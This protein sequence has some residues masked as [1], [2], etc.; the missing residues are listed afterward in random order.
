MAKAFNLTGIDFGSGD[1]QTQLQGLG[2]FTSNYNTLLDKLGTLEG[3]KVTSSGITIGQKIGDNTAVKLGN[4][5]FNLSNLA[6]I[7]NNVPATLQPQSLMAQ[8]TGNAGNVTNVSI[9]NISLSEVKNGKDFMDYLQNF[10]ATMIQN[11]YTR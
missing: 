8:A 5:G 1:W 4:G 11:F 10:N 7:S 6:S 2:D 3:N 9:G